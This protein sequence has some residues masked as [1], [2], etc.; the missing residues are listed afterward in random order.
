MS[1]LPE[2]K[3]FQKAHTY[4]T[5]CPKLCR[6]A[7]PVSTVEARETTTPW[8]KMS[9]L[10]HVA[11]GNL[12]LSEE[13]TEL[14]YDCT[15]CMR[16]RTFCD[17]RNEVAAALGAG[18]VAALRSETAPPAAYEI[19]ERHAERQEAAAA[20]GRE[21]FSREE[22]ERRSEVVFVPGCTACAV[23]PESAR[24]S[25]EALE[26][27]LERSVRVEIDQCCGLPL[28]D[29]GD[30]EGFLSA[31]RR[32]Q[33]ALGDAREIVFADPGCL[34]A[35]QVSGP[36]LG[37]EPRS[38]MRHLAVI[39]SERLDRL[40]P[41]PFEGDVRYHD[42]CK[43]GRGLGVYEEP[44]AVLRKILGRAPLELPMNRERAE[45]SGAGGGLPR[46]HPATSAE[47]AE[48]RLEE[49][50]RAG[51]GVLVTACPGSAHRLRS[52]E[53]GEVLSFGEL[54]ARAS[55]PDGGPGPRS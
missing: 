8:G 6:F 4:C 3:P 26:N 49:H 50:A 41:I 15:G 53:R 39:A 24:A 32:L 55:R 52:S 25:F 51:G 1:H 2:A 44:R 12:P 28:L 36:R 30:A 34:H 46:T 48:E 17:H 29:A 38:G 19:V 20:S 40:E 18:R 47:I 22:R 11:E 14:W 31:A 37:L 9:S 42:S 16:C 35:L 5:Y 33:Q 27:L 23:A 10:H 45:C 54:L 43:L 21:I 13:Q 7:C